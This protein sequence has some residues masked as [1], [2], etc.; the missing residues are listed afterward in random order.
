MQQKL[1]KN[2]LSN[3]SIGKLKILLT[4]EPILAQLT[5]GHDTI[6]PFLADA[7]RNACRG[8]GP[9]FLPHVTGSVQRIHFIY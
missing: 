9:D 1:Q 6:L 4:M 7:K 3:D 2:I 8:W 5:L